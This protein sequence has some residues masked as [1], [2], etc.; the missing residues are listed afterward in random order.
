MLLT[1]KLSAHF[2]LAEFL[3]SET[4]ARHGIDNTPAPEILH[5]LQRNAENM[6]AVRALLGVPLHISSGYRCLA[7]NRA[8]GSKDTS[9]HVRGLAADFEAPEF[10]PPVDICH[11]IVASDI[12]YDQLLY[13]HTWVH[14]GWPA[15]DAVPR[16]QVLTLMPGNTYATGI[17]EREVA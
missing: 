11:A 12:V 9:A 13:E 17:I 7:L 10:G 5:A 1:D 3:R 4:A 2:T 16:R 14:I 8:I 6:E 15:A